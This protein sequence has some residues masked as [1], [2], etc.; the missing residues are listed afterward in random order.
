MIEKGSHSKPIFVG[1]FIDILS[2]WN[3]ADKDININ[4]S[5]NVYTI[6]LCSVFMLCITLFVIWKCLA[7]LSSLVAQY[8]T[9]I[10]SFWLKITDW[11]ILYYN[12]QGLQ[13]IEKKD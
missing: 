4:S 8:K 7:A 3:T 11:R 12:T 1:S 9:C 10:I 13:G 2:I 6:V 5:L